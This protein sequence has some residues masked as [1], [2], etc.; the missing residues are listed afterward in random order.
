[1]RYKVLKLASVAIAILLAACHEQS[2]YL[3]G[4][5]DPLVEINAATENEGNFTPEAQ[6]G[7]G[8]LRCN[9]RWKAKSLSDE[10]LTCTTVEGEFNDTVYFAMSENKGNTRIGKIVISNTV[11]EEKFDTLTVRQQCAVSF[12]PEGYKIKIESDD[13][14][15]PLTGESFAEVKF[16]VNSS[17]AWRAFTKATDGW[18]T[19]MTKKGAASGSGSLIVSENETITPRSMYIYVQSVEYP[20]L[21]DSILLTQS[22]RPLRLEVISPTNKQIMLDGAESQFIFSVKGDGEWKIEGVPEWIELEKTE[23]EGDAN[24]LVKVAATSSERTAQLTIQS[25]VQAEKTDIL[26]IEQKYIPDGRMKDSLALVA[27]YQATKGE[28]WAYPWKPEL[29]LSESNWPGVFFDMVD[30]ELRVVDLS[31]MSFNL[32]GS[33]PN[34]IGWLTEVIKIKVQHN[35]LSGT[36]PASLNRLTNLTHLYITSN[37]FSGEFP[38]IPDLQKLTWIEMD[39]N[40]F[41]GEFP[42]VFSLLPKLSTLKMKYNNFDRNTCIPARFGGWKLI[43]INPQREV[44]GDAKT[45]YNLVDCPK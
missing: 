2:E 18:S 7:Y 11:G 22:G 14:K 31:L 45:D 44:Y 38:D 3:F 9:A 30:G 15:E 35:K 4:A 24:V 21:K 41:T 42:P 32:E 16:E 29:P 36:L 26:T 33:L 23:Y 19:V 12:I 39:F 6:T 40:R 8:L 13:L 20:T 28:N 1:M 37:Q 25:L 17:T 34:E 5:K 43:Y 10:W 27:I